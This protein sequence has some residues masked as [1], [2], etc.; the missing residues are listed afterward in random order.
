MTQSKGQYRL[1]P[2]TPGW[3]TRHQRIL[4]LASYH[5][6][7]D[8]EAPILSVGPDA[9]QS[10]TNAVF[11]CETGFHALLP[12]S[13]KLGPLGLIIDRN[14]ACNA[15]A[16]RSDLEQHLATAL[17][18]DRAA[19]DHAGE[20]V[21]RLIFS[22]LYGSNSGAPDV[23]TPPAPYTIVI[24]EP[25]LGLDRLREMLVF[26]QT[27]HPGMPAYVWNE[28]GTSEL[29]DV[30][31]GDRVSIVPVGTNYWTLLE[32][33]AG[34]Y[35]HSS[36]AGF[37]AIYAG[38]KPR[39][40]GTPF[41]AGWGLTQ[42]ETDLPHR[43]RALTRAQ[44]FL[45][46]MIEFPFWYDP[47][48]DARA[49][50]SRVV[51]II[52]AEHSVLRADHGPK[53]AVDLSAW[54]RP[55]MRGFFGQTGSLR[56]GRKATE[57]NELV[58]HWGMKNPDET[59]SVRIEDG[60]L[61]SKGLGAAHFAPLS[62][63]ADDL[64]MYF[65]ATGESRLEKLISA[66]V[67]LPRSAIARA[68]RLRRRVLDLRITK[69]NLGQSAS[70]LA[71]SDQKM[72]LVPGQ[73]EDDAS[74][75]YGCDTVSTNLALLERA[76]ME[77]PDAF[78]IYKPH[79]DVV[80]GLRAGEIAATQAQELANAVLPDASPADLL[81]LVDEVWTMTSLMGFEALM[82]G[83]AVTCLGLPFYAGWGLT[84]DL[85]LA[86][87]RRKERPTL[88]QLVHAALIDYPR[89]LDPKTGLICPPE[90]IVDRLADP[91]FKQVPM[92]WIKRV[93][94]RFFPSQR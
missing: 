46:A 27:E 54:K 93:A 70:I 91:D 66:S 94:L 2:D 78:L 24:A 17:L 31:L 28:S 15:G 21:E 36:F 4:G 72:I 56:F 80:A 50:L 8:G 89:Y 25:A 12:R 39:V 47:F 34:V 1:P 74:I 23:T 6:V 18:D 29:D 26:A 60:F 77:N 61:R 13:R 20:L 83:K 73:V 51:D 82:R 62:L 48:E 52:E 63:V 85:G 5:R 33:A 57:E 9:A 86:T 45:G 32:G 92:P 22:G 76:R 37:L 11:V 41:Y 68:E 42:D 30:D 19:L 69:Y 40:F 71:S 81:D 87:L 49:D 7:D 55:H 3:T 84:Q 58:L 35:C 67:D 64:G 53:V 79:P 14:G 75:R 43:R 16:Q 10:A 88:D 59:S 44:L 90:V 65:D 38:H